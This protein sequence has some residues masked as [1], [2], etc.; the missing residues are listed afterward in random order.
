M[1]LR[2]A[3]TNKS[4]DSFRAVYCWQTVRCLELWA[5][6]I[7]DLGPQSVRAL[8]A[9]AVYV[10]SFHVSMPILFF[11]GEIRGLWAA[12]CFCQHRKFSFVS[13]PIVAYVCTEGPNAVGVSSRVMS[14]MCRGCVAGA[15]G[16]SVPPGSDSVGISKAGPCASLL[17]TTIAHCCGAAPSRR[18]GKCV[19]A[20]GPTSVGDADVVRPGQT[21]SGIL[22]SDHPCIQLRTT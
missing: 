19:G 6:V 4:P 3:L 15:A 1:T 16:I 10:H 21:T 9:E 2:G 7:T 14:E 8:S 5:R 22:T 17:S 20:P 12:Q 11:A 18:V 13:L